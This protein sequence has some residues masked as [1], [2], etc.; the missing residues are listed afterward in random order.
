MGV[1]SNALDD[2][3]GGMMGGGESRPAEVVAEGEYR[4]CL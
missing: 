1:K 3:R 4:L 2:P